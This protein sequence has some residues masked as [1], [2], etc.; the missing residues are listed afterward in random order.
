VKDDESEEDY[1]KKGPP[2][3]ALCYLPIIPRFKRLFA[4]VNDAKNFRWHANGK[5]FDGF[6]R[7]VF[8]SPQWKKLILC[9]LILGVINEILHLVLQ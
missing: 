7:H 2:A 1:V 8:D 3:K 4:N 6:L 9:F 5:K